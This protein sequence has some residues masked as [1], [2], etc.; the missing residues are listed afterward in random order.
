MILPTVKNK[1]ILATQPLDDFEDLLNSVDSNMEFSE[2]QVLYL[3][4]DVPLLLESFDDFYFFLL[5]S[6][7]KRMSQKCYQFFINEKLKRLIYFFTCI[8]P[9]YVPHEIIKEFWKISHFENITDGFLLRYQ[10]S[11]WWEMWLICHWNIDSLKQ[12][13]SFGHVLVPKNNQ[14]II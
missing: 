4:L 2:T 8:L 12:K 13:L 10:N 1:S 9:N 11:L 14:K 7:S 6:Y 3:Q 5:D